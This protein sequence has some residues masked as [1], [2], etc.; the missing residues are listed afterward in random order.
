MGKKVGEKNAVVGFKIIFRSV[1]ST[2]SWFLSI[3]VPNRILKLR[4]VG[5]ARHPF[6]IPHARNEILAGVD[7]HFPANVLQSIRLCFTL[8][9]SLRRRLVYMLSEELGLHT[10]NTAGVKIYNVLPP[11]P[12]ALQTGS[13]MSVL[14]S[15]TLC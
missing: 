6:L 14:R 4:P 8:R 13:L 3:Q 12:P 15:T 10:P 5:E 11:P 7:T 2:L 1:S 9:A